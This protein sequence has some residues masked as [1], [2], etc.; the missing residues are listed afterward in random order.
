MRAEASPS[1]TGPNL[2]GCYLLMQLGGVGGQHMAGPMQRCV[3]HQKDNRAEFRVS[4]GER[5]MG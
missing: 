5:L 1:H 4:A 2:P 3:A